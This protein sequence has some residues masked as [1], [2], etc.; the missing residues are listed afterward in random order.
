MLRI[1]SIA[2]LLP[3]VSLADSLPMSPNDVPVFYAMLGEKPVYH[4]AAFK[5]QQAFLIQTGFTPTYDA[6]TGYVTSTVTNKVNYAIDNY[7]PFTSKNVAV[8]LGTAY[9]VCVK[10][11]FTK[12][13]SDPLDHRIMHTVSLSPGTVSADV[14]IPFEAIL[15]KR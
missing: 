10:K 15:P 2:L 4:E 11:Q 8:V 9:T 7:T 3:A 12:Q 5:A 1:V 13:F 14:R 6:I